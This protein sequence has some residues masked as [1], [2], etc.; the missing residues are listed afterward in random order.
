VTVFFA[1][2]ANVALPDAAVASVA[3]TVTWPVNG[4]ANVPDMTPLAG[5]MVTPAGSPVSLH[6][7]VVIVVSESVAAI[8]RLTAFDSGSVIWSATGVT[9]TVLAAAA[10]NSVVPT[11]SAEPESRTQA[12][13][14]RIR[15]RLV[16]VDLRINAPV[17]SFATRATA[18]D[19]YLHRQRA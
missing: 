14:T 8:C 1:V 16:I 9:V 7:K 10:A 11:A 6:V 18:G 5:S 2:Q 17:V 3:V 15:I 12:V 4:V 13:T 19:I